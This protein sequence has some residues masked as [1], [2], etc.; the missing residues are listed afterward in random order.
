MGAAA[1][2]NLQII[3]R[4]KKYETDN[5]TK[6]AI[7]RTTRPI[8]SFSKAQLRA[9]LGLIFCFSFS[10]RV[11]EHFWMHILAAFCASRSAAAFLNA[12][13]GGFLCIPECWRVRGYEKCGE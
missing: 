5:F 6:N 3:I 1:P 4:F 8:S 12:H 7:E 9:F 2:A 10:K 11:S 13:F